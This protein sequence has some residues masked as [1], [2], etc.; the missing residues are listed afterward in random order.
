[1][2]GLKHWF[3]AAALT[4]AVA[5]A[6]A[7]VGEVRFE[8][9][10]V[11]HLPA[12]Q[13]AVTVQLRPGIEFRQEIL[14][15][16]VKR[17]YH[18][19]NF[20]DVVSEVRPQE[21]DLVEVLFKVRLKPRVS[22]VKYVGNVK[23]PTHEL[24]KET[25]V[26]AGSRLNDRELRE[27]ANKLRKFYADKG[28]TD[29]TVTP[30]VLPDGE[31]QVSLTWKIDESL[32]RRINDVT[33][34]GATVFSQWDLRHSIANQYSYFNW[35]PFVNEYLNRGLLNQA[36]L[37]LDRARLR[38]KYHDA[39]YLDFKIEDL[40][41]RPTADDP[42]FVD[43]V[44][45]VSEG[46]PY[47]TGPCTFTGGTV[48]TEA[49]LL[50]CLR[51][52]EGELFSRRD[53][54][55]T[56]RAVVAMYETLGY[57]DAV[58][59]P[60]RRENF[61]DHTVSVDFQIS[62]G[63]KYTVRDVVIAG[64][65]QTKDKVIRR[66]LAIQP[67]DPVDRNRIEVSK[68]RLMGM[69]YFQKVEANPVAADALGEKDVLFSVTEKPD[70]F[71]LRVGA[72][73]SDVNSVFGMAEIST[74]N[75]DLFNPGNWFY[76]GGQ[77]MRIQGIFGVENAG[78]NVDFVEPWLA[79]LP[80]R[81]E[82]SA[83][84]NQVEYEEWTEERVGARTSISKQ[85]FDDFTTVTVGYKFEYV[86]V[87]DIGHRLEQ[88]MRDTGQKGH[89]LVSQ[90]SISITRDTR[91]NFI[92]PTSGYQINLF[93]S[94][95]P[96]IF[97]S[98]HN[99]YRMEGKASYY[100]NFFDGA[101]VLMMGGKIGTVSSFDRDKDVP[102]FE[103][104]FLGGGDSLRGFEYRTVSPTYNRENIGGQTMLLLTAEA[105]HPIYGPIRGAAFVDAGN[106]WR[107]SYS[108]GFSQMNIGVGYGLRIR[109]PVLNAPIRLDLAY[110]V[111]NNQTAASSKLRFHFNVG[112]TF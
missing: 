17:L 73:A 18:T 68:Q 112:F 25:G 31:G 101:I 50:P 77:R 66:E 89:H 75:F 74:D 100:C 109:V 95:T 61:E 58:C 67:G 65:T 46:E 93:S 39:G 82:L 111:L 44:F 64:N 96:K 110:P 104:Y 14:D 80:I 42:E 87:T 102:I 76:G 29:A 59:R 5:A 37:D 45:Q 3:G 60:V 4:V 83:Y 38:D 27:S 56:A 88:Y 94:I 41:V 13:L 97:G 12:E 106:A 22:E 30:V 6:A 53:E 52:R 98:S 34:E 70:R 43:L 85:I 15:E 1:M 107:N 10:G 108:M 103:R 86:N 91:D 35:I 26:A 78:F 57:A 99:Y 7:K 9:Q 62:E 92:E 20:A 19:G 90:P 79:D 54:E 81:Y 21:G 2:N 23:Y 36:E 71:N 11:Q 33:F 16:D 8:Q 32:R 40:S 49:E 105:S 55:A 84:M 47:R 63:R 51:L 72:G 69:G 48:F 28:Y 24:A